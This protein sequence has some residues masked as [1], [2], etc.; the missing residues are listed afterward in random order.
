[1]AD[2]AAER[3]S[4][5]DAAALAVRTE[6]TAQITTKQLLRETVTLVVGG[7]VTYC[8]MRAMFYL[9]DPQREEKDKS[10]QT[11]KQMLDRLGLTEEVTGPLDE[12]EASLCG[13]VLNPD[14][15]NVGFDEIGG[16]EKVK[17]SIVELVV[18]P[19][20]HPELFT[21]KL[22][23]PP[24]GILLYGP[25]GTGKTMMAKAIAKQ[26]GARFINLSQSTLQ[27][28]WFGE[29]VKL[30]RAV[31][32]LAVKLQVIGAVRTRCQL[33]TFSSYLSR[34]IGVSLTVL[35]MCHQSCSPR[36]YSSMRS[37]RSYES[38]LATTI[39]RTQT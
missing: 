19:L 24:K 17:R 18:F 6:D 25:P 21:G 13:D 15:I 16:M 4:W 20:Q 33:S 9:L 11:K 14:D 27:N 5:R 26:S 36:L 7:I 34:C 37:M 1:M 23:R 30:V 10:A 28:K 35:C 32:K 29:S 8:S 2:V 39:R 12:H 3:L 38:V 22:L 31:F